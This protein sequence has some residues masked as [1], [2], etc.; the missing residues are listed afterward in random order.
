MKQIM[1]FF[2]TTA[3]GGFFVLLP[4]VLLVLLLTEALDL[5]VLLATPIA[6]LFPKGTFDELDH[7]VLIAFIILTIVSFLIGLVMRSQIGTRFGSR[8][9]SKVLAPVPGYTFLKNL[10]QSFSDLKKESKFQPALMKHADG[11]RSFAYV[12]EDHGDGE[13]TVLLPHSPAATVG[14]IRIVSKDQVQILDTN[15]AEL[16]RIVGYWGIGTGE[17]LGKKKNE[18]ITT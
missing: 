7:P 5:V 4:I 10:T 6:D 16:T 1:E 13:L 2:K 15:L 8:V 11:S 14:V 12:I 9:E 18:P 17:L 3:L